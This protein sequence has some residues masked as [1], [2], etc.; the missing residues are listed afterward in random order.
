MTELGLKGSEFCRNGFNREMG[1]IA[2]SGVGCGAQ[3]C[4]VRG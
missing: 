3:G 1:G 4:A 2:E